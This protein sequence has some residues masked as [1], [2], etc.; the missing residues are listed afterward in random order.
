MCDFLWGLTGCGNWSGH[1]PQ[2]AGPH[3]TYTH[4]INFFKK[5]LSMLTLAAHILKLEQYR[6][7]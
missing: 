4:E 5:L 6:E 7:D 3:V 1:K 2:Q